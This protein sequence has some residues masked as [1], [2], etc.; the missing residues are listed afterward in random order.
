M[1]NK[2]VREVVS[3]V[4]VLLTLLVPNKIFGEYLKYETAAFPYSLAKVSMMTLEAVFIALVLVYFAWR[5]LR[6]TRSEQ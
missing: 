3:G 2:I 1:A 5:I 4:L 6:W